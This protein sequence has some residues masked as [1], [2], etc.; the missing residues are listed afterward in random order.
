MVEVLRVFHATFDDLRVSQAR[1]GPR[2]VHV[3]R[4]GGGTAARVS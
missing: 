2:L 1:A 4:H 3:A